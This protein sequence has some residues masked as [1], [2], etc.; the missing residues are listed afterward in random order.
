MNDAGSQLAAPPR[1][2]APVQTPLLRAEGITRQYRM[3]GA[4][5]DVLRGCCL[6]VRSG[7]F[8]AIMGKSGSGKSTLLHILGALDVPQAG[9]VYFENEPVFAPESR[10]RMRTSI[11]DVLSAAERWRIRLRRRMVGFV[12]QFYHLLPELNVLENVLL[13]Q[14][15]DSSIWGWWGKAATARLVAREIVERVGLA[16]RATHRPNQ[17]SGGERQRV[18]IARALVNQ[19]RILLADEP[20]GN[21][22]AETGATILA[23]LEG[24]HKDGQTIVMVTHDASVAER[25]DRV[26]R[27]ESGRLD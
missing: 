8:L 6:S 10:R 27:L 15:V 2:A 1:A 23:L 22:D 4:T 9:Q 26:L 21:L 7:E 5:L 17:L 18:A 13:P 25:A 14:M 3:G 16:Q 11:T 19:P 12:F 24:L 20:T